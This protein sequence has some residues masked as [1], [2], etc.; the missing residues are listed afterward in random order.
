M[1]QVTVTTRDG[2]E[3]N[4]DSQVGEPLM[5]TI[6]SAGISELLALCGGMCSCGTCHV[7]IDSEFL[8]TLPSISDD[9]N[10]L[11]SASAFRKDNSR[12]SCQ[13][14]MTAEL[15]GLRATIAPED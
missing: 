13:I 7:Y 6:T 15:D 8:G 11:L 4:L 14:R 1:P 9:E 3:Q 5:Q 10:D 2:I 12:L